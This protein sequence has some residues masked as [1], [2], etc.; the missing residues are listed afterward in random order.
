M[1]IKHLREW[2][3][4]LPAELDE[5]E[6]VFR[7]IKMSEAS[8]HVLA[9]DIPIAACGIDEG[10]KEAYFTDSDSSAVLSSMD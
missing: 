1:K 5:H 7:D 3:R 6:L 8:D 10:N 2:L 9:K 4:T